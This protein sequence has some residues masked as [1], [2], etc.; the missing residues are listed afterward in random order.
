LKKQP[1]KAAFFFAL[2]VKQDVG[3]NPAVTNFIKE[4]NCIFFLFSGAIHV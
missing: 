4:H 1:G 3:F 2:P